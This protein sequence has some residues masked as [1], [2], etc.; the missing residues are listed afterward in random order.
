MWDRLQVIE[1]GSVF[2]IIGAYLGISF[3]AIYLK[4]TP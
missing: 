2:Y 4:G 1:A 3:D